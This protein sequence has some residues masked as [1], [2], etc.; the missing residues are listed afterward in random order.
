MPPQLTRLFIIFAAIGVLF[1]IVTWVAEPASFGW[2]GHYRA[3]ALTELAARAP[4]YV[5]RDV[6]AECHADEAKTHKNG[7]HAKISCQT[8]H[9]PG[10]KHIEEPTTEN[11]TRPVPAKF[12]IRCHEANFARPKT[13]PQIVPAEHTEGKACNACHVVHNPSEMVEAKAAADSGATPQ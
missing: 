9:G 8:C 12:C 3:D 11:I 7:V 6:C 2:Y 1:I 13:F 5:P 4:H 10:V